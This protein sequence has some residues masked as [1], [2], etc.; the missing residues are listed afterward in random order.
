MFI[1]I[2]QNMFYSYLV[3][4]LQ[5]GNIFLISFH[6]C[7]VWVDQVVSP[8]HSGK[9]FFSHKSLRLLCCSVSK[10]SLGVACM[11]LSLCHHDALSVHFLY[12]SICH[13]FVIHYLHCGFVINSIKFSLLSHL[14]IYLCKNVNLMSIYK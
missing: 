11:A 4:L 6:L 13:Q 1:K 2:H 9:C 3:R 5:L 7:C 10:Q 8:H 12:D 14:H